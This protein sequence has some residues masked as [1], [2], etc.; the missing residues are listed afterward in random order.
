MSNKSTFFNFFADTFHFV[1]DTFHFVADTFHFVAD[2]FHFVANAFNFVADTFHF[3]ANA[4][5]FVADT[6]DF[7]VTS[8]IL[9]STV[10]LHP[11]LP[12][13]VTVSESSEMRRRCLVPMYMTSDLSGLSYLDN[14][15][16]LLLHC[17]VQYMQCAMWSLLI[18]VYM[19]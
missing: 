9:L 11:L 6:F 12:A 1:A 8:P 19:N 17:I 7:L 10:P 3:V 2:T 4:F 5:D 14:Y 15:T 16:F 13:M 18:S